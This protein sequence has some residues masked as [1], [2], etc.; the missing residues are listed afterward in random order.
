MN[1]QI[2]MEKI[3]DVANNAYHNSGNNTMTDNEFD[4]LKEQLVNEFPNSKYKNKIGEDIVNN[5]IKLPFHLGS[6]NKLKTDKSINNWTKKYNGNYCIMDKL[7]GCSALYIYKEGK[8][9]LF[10]RGNGDYGQDITK[11][12]ARLQD[13]KCQLPIEKIKMLLSGKYKEIELL[14]DLKSYINGWEAS[15]QNC[16]RLWLQY[17]DKLTK[18]KW[19]E[20]FSHRKSAVESWYKCDNAKA[21]DN[22]VYYNMYG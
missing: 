6:M 15:A 1:K 19:I 7:D 17:E 3:L 8:Y 12:C 10:T 4:C 22:T 20:L 13:E 5:K 21:W 18:Q 9:K 2:I 14:S 16:R 11:F